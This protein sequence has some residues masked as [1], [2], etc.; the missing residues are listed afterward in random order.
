MKFV[1]RFLSV[2]VAEFQVVKTPESLAEVFNPSLLLKYLRKKKIRRK[3]TKS[4]TNKER[5][6]LEMLTNCS[7]AFRLHLLWSAKNGMAVNDIA[8]FLQERR[9]DG[10]RGP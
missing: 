2:I 1:L 5:K 9:S 6:K 8:L 4:Q 10:R 7:D 3:K